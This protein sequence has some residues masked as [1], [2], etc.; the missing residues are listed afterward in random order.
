MRLVAAAVLGLAAL[1]LAAGAVRTRD[2][3]AADRL[4][5]ACMELRSRRDALMASGLRPFMDRLFVEDAAFID[6]VVHELGEE[7]CAEVERRLRE[8]FSIGALRTWRAT[9]WPA[10][11][12]ERFRTATD[13]AR[14]RCPAVMREALRPIAGTDVEAEALGREACDGLIPSLDAFASR[15]QETT[16]PLGLH[17]WVTEMEALADQLPDPGAPAP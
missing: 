14:A 5:A 6:E 15:D 12:L 8:P 4:A 17:E 10:A 2:L 7:P 11:R 9:P 1:L 13:R 16:E 3:A